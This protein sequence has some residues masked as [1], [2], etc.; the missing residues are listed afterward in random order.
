[1]DEAVPRAGY[2][3]SS[4]VGEELGLYALLRPLLFALPAEV[5]HAVALAALR[6]LGTLPARRTAPGIDLLGLSFPN[7]LGVAA[8]LDKNA[9]A[10]AGLA[11]LG[12]GFVEVGTVT[13]RPQ[14]GNPKP[15]LFRLTEDQGLINRLGFNSQGAQAVAANLS[16]LRGRTG[17]P[18]GI[19]I[20]KNRDTPL[21]A[22]S[23][24]YLACMAVLG[25]F[26]DYLTV[27]LSSPNTPGLRD[28]QAPR[29]ARSL[30]S[31]L[32]SERDRLA[33]NEGGTGI[34][35][36]VKFAPDLA[37]R[38]LEASVDAVLEAGADGLVATNTTLSR[39]PGLRSRSANQAGGLSGRPLFPIAV[40]VV[41]R[42]RRVAGDGP[43]VIGVGG[44][45]TREDALAMREAGADLVQMYTGL[46]FR[47]PGLVRGLRDIG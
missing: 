17:V 1:V 43:V 4:E 15:R 22:A 31:R 16:R 3:A 14:P 45:G 41:R 39:P 5:A 9:A 40:E 2:T 11:R 44:V 47:G 18:V 34:P 12:F 7:R 42:V 32:A 46:V 28:L 26:A 19:N 33:A 8:G 25:E 10:V 37:P 27:N 36:L 29:E 13:P 24:D 20:G 6:C 23:D 21:A 30:V 35:L 38:D